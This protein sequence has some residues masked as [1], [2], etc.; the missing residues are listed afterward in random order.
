MTETSNQLT[1][2]AENVCNQNVTRGEMTSNR[3]ET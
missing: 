3:T 2:L 1:L